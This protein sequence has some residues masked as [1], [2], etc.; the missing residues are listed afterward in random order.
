MTYY[1]GWKGTIHKYRASR[2][3]A[4]C[5]RGSHVAPGTRWRAPCSSCS[6]YMSE[7]E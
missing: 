1:V 6:N 2:I 3:Y 5:T 4:T 7:P